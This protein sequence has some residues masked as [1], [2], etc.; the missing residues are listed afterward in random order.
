MEL[1]FSLAGIA[2]GA[3]LAVYL[4]RNG[5]CFRFGKREWLA[6]ACLTWMIF[7]WI[8]ISDD[9]ALANFYAES[10]SPQESIAKSL[11]AVEFS[12][13]TLLFLP[14]A[15]EFVCNEVGISSRCSGVASGAWNPTMS[16]WSPSVNNR[17]PPQT[18]I[19]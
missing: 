14:F 5:Q 2:V 9:L 12:Q 6:I 19:A 11:A 18:L 16:Q 4:V 3:S 17:P 15:P 1:I 10:R 7:T 13:L 8:S